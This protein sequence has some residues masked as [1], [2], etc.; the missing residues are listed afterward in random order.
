MAMTLSGVPGKGFVALS[1]ASTSMVA[2]DP[3]FTTAV[4][5]AGCASGLVE[6]TTAS[7]MRPGVPVD[8][9]SRTPILSWTTVPFTASS[10]ALISRCW[11]VIDGLNPAGSG[12][13]R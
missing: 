2:D 7:A 3:R 6:G 5:G 13:I 10:L 9:A 4:S 1:L 12:S 8:V 11:P